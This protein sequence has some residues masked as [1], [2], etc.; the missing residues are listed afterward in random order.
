M[1]RNLI[2]YLLLFFSHKF[3]AQIEKGTYVPSISLNCSYQTSPVKDSTANSTQNYIWNAGC[4]IGFGKFIKDNLS[5]GAS[6][7]YTYGYSRKTYVNNNSYQA[8]TDNKNYTYS[9]NLS[10]SLLKY[11]FIGENFALRFGPTLSAYFSEGRSNSQFYIFD[12]SNG[13]YSQ[14]NPT[15]YYN[16]LISSGSLSAGI[17]YFLNKNI[18]LTGNMGFFAINYTYSPY[19]KMKHPNSEAYTLN[20][21]LTPSFNAFNVGLIYFIRPKK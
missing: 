1:K 6:F 14:Q 8:N 16:S 9:E 7:N 20:L 21:S 10:I 12:A 19:Q 3:L 17:Q 13:T 5:L 15:S 18:A 4:T 11:K 2:L